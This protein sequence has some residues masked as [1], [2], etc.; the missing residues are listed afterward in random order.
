LASFQDS[1]TAARC[2]SPF[3]ATAAAFLA[4]AFLA[5]V[6]FLAAFFFGAG[7]A[8]VLLVAS[9]VSFMS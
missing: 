7:L 1:A 3:V 5:V 2:A 6:A 9:P 8:V 4:G